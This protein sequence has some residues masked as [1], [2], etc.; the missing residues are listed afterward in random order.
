MSGR[1]AVVACGARRGIHTQLIKAV[2][3]YCVLDKARL[4]LCGR[5]INADLHQAGF[6]KAMLLIY[7]LRDL[8]PRIGQTQ[9]CPLRLEKTA[10]PQRRDNSGYNNYKRK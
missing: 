9:I 10:A 8:A 7:T 3:A 4:L 1:F 5:L 6:E 2:V